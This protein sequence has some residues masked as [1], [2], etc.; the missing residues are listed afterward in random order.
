MFFYQPGEY[1][2]I[3]RPTFFGL[4]TLAKYLFGASAI[5]TG[6]Q[7]LVFYELPNKEI[8]I[9]VNDPPPSLLNSFTHQQRVRTESGKKENLQKHMYSI[10]IFFR[11]YIVKNNPPTKKRYTSYN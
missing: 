5:K 7:I 11:K 6:T 10:G 3:P 9:T 8:R 4:N 2:S 1:D